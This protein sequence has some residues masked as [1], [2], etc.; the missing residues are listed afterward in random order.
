MEDWAMLRRR[1]T[2]EQIVAKL[3]QVE[4]QTAQGAPAAEVIRSITMIEVTCYLRGSEYGGLI[5]LVH[6][7]DGECVDK[8]DSNA[9]SVAPPPN[10]EG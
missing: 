5:L 7:T 10:E 2:P 3:W 8:C 4:V 9:D 1:H 6:R